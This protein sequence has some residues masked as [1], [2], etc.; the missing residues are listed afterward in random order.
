MKCDKD[1]FNC[2]F[3]DC[4]YDE[5]EQKDRTEY[6]HQWYLKSKEPKKC[7]WCGKELH[8]EVIR[9]SKH[10]FCDINCVLCQLYKENEHKMR[11]CMIKGV[12]G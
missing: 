7:F 10:N 2:K 6:L 12:K 11:F 3:D 4:I 1:C 8:G 5:P 9:M